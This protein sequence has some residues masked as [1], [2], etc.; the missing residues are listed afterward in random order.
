MVVN[1]GDGAYRFV[2]ADVLAVR[3][4]TELL[5]QKRVLSFRDELL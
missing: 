1:A 4:T 3:I 5:R 2:Y